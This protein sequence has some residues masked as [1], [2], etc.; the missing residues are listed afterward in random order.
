M[1]LA[2]VR[3]ENAKPRDKPYTLADGFGLHLLIT[4]SGSKLWLFR[5]RYAGKA[6]MLSLGSFPEV[7]LAAARRKR[8]DARK[9]LAAGSDPSQQR[10]LDKIAA[11]DAAKNTFGALAEE[12]LNNLE[13]SG[14]A[15]STMRKNRWYLQ[16]LAGELWHRPIT[17]ITSPEIL[18]IL[19]RIEKGGR[20]ETAR[21]VRGIIGAVFR[22]A[23]NT[24]RATND[25][26]YPLRRSLLKPEV[27]HRPAITDERRLGSLMLAISFEHRLG[28][29][30]E[31][32]LKL[33]Q[34]G[35][36]E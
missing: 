34:D 24:L 29:R 27:Q 30:I 12:H 23:I 11:A 4:P 9:L 5:Y 3:V 28:A 8:E 7:S 31:S 2:S 32:I 36:R 19:K 18:A 15:L 21:K 10:K 14:T 26:T 35:T 20:R 16:D 13:E 1:A 33:P 17:E 22:L 6:N 25:P